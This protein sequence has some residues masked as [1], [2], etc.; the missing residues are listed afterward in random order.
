MAEPRVGGESVE[1][2]QEAFRGMKARRESDGWVSISGRLD[3]VPGE[4]LMRALRAT[5]IDLPRQIG[6]SR[7]E[8][9]AAALDE[10][11]RQVELLVGRTPADASVEEVETPVDASADASVETAE[12]PDEIVRAEP[13]DPDVS[14]DARVRGR[15]DRSR[16]PSGLTLVRTPR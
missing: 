6:S 16:H 5:E 14:A 11:A 13:T 12:T 9:R 10:I 15:V 2:I 7:D 4:A 3:P 1:L 8:H